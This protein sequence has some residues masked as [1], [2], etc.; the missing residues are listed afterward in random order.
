MTTTTV[1]NFPAK[2][3]VTWEQFASGEWPE[4]P[5][6]RLFREVVEAVTTQARAAL[7]EATGRVDRAREL[8]L[9]GAVTPS[10]DGTSYTVR[11]QRETGTS[12]TVNSVCNCPDDKQA[13]P[14]K[15]R[16]AVWIWRKARKTVDQQRAMAVPTPQ[17]ATPLA[18]AAA[19][20]PEAPASAN[21][22]VTLE[23]RQVQITLRDRDE[24][25]LLTRLKE[26]LQQFPM[27]ADPPPP[28][29]PAK[30]PAAKSQQDGWCTKHKVQMTQQHNAKGTWWSH[31]LADGTWCKGK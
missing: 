20:L 26:L 25:R 21:A 6:K 16:I 28:E 11:S 3:E 10:P 5:A 2:I 29:K 31:H 19:P 4:S 27:P 23:G 7:P 30:K 17:A 22:F 15:H 1:P 8:V 12:Y 14:C 13:R 9:A 24:T 18:E